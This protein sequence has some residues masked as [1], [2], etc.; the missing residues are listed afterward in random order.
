LRR[1]GGGGRGG[2]VALWD[3][4]LREGGLL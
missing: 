4:G 1:P 3:R 2:V